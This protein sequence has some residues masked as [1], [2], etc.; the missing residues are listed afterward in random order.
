LFIWAVTQDT[1]NN[2]LLNAALQPDGL[3]KFRKRNGVHTGADD[4]ITG[5]Y[6][7]CFLS[8]K[9]FA[10]ELRNPLPLNP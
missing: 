10:P 6:D 9:P 5:V 4:W 2:D 7:R 1:A 3:G 8:G